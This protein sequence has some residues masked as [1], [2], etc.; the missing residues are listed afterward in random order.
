M[1]TATIIATILTLFAGLA[2]FMY[3]LMT[4]SE[5]LE[6]Q[7]GNKLRNMF[8]KATSN[9]YMGLAV[10]AG[11]TAIIQSSSATTV[12]VVGFVNAGV[13]SLFQATAIIMGANIGTTITAVLIS[14]PITEIMAASAIIGV[15]MVLF[16][17]KTTVKN[18]GY[19]IIGLG[20]IFAGLFVMSSSMKVFA[21][22]Q[23][24]RNF[25]ASTS[26]PFLL[27]LIGLLVTALIQSSSATTGIL[28]TLA[29]VGLIGINNSIFL[30]L[31]IN[32]GTCITAILAAIGTSVNAQRAAAIHLLFNITG[33]IFFSIILAFPFIRKGI[34]S[35]LSILGSWLPNDGIGAQIAAFHIL[36]NV[37]TTLVMLPFI[38]VLV[39]LATHLVPKRNGNGSE[40][41]LKFLNDLI[42]ET[43]PIAIAQ[44]KKEILRMADMAMAN[45]EIAVEGVTETSLKNK[46]EF[47]KRE[48]YLDW[49]NH[50]IPSF[51]VKISSKHIS[52]D[53]SKIVA[54]YYH[55]I[56]DIERIGD[57]AENLLE[58]A[59]K[60]DSDG[61][62]FSDQ[63]KSEIKEMYGA[64]LELYNVAIEGFVNVDISLNRK[65]ECLEDCVDEYK[66]NLSSTHIRR[67]NEGTCTAQTGALFLSLVSNFERIADHIRNIFNSIRKYAKPIKPVKV[68]VTK[69]LT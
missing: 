1:T 45:L 58:Y 47:D 10:G 6:K 27:V 68:T 5:R 60:M 54:S 55:V 9:K 34:I 36:F 22:Y 33:T 14:L 39:S 59:E 11:V 61:L 2:V 69:K 8:N 46:E 15:F 63:A 25:F 49:L 53:D 3:G 7:A 35:I 52:F 26:N 42:L 38:N 40:L 41:E 12:M 13:L 18:I 32:I 19:I 56:S 23:P 51:L 50:E 67:L 29:N 37:I 31:G 30:I 21:D 43:P 66:K 57:Y 44:A 20:M 48:K 16:A 17:K 28:I 62:K 4:M 65:V 64:L 24:F